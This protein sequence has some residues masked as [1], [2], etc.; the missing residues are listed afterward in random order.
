[1]P[2][3]HLRPHDPITN[4]SERRLLLIDPHPLE[5]NPI[6][7]SQMAVLNLG[8]CGGGDKENAPPAAARGIAVKIH[9][10]MKRPGVGGKATRRRPPLRDITGLFL[11][12][13]S[14]PPPA[15]LLALAEAELPEAVRARAGAPDGAAAKQGRYS[16]RKGFR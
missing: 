13:P 2:S 16:L 15:A 6:D 7:P 14:R 11:A 12:A 9:V 1:M 5:G 3:S 10:T 8:S 4:T